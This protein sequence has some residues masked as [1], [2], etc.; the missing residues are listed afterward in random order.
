M[1][2]FLT[3]YGLS[4][5]ATICLMT[6]LW[7]YQVKTKDATFLDLVWASLIILFSFIWYFDLGSASWVGGFSLLLLFVWSSRLIIHLS[8]DR[9][10][11][12]RKEDPRYAALRRDNGQGFFFFLFQINGALALALSLSI[13]PALQVDKVSAGFL[14][15][16]LG[17]WITSIVGEWLADRQLKKFKSRE[18][19][20]SRT[21]REGLWKYSRHPN[22]FFEFLHW[23]SYPFLGASS[24]IWWVALFAPALMYIFLNYVTGIP[25]AERLSLRS[26]DDYKDYQRNTNAF[27]PWFPK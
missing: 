9:L 20:R 5:L 1:L 13:I 22:Y 27:F 12:G 10:G 25:I 24:D 21:C 26:R 14:S 2:D 18:G 19:N 17:I 4:Q 6:G 7:L 8:G 23:T 16:G 15:V 11:S 3:T